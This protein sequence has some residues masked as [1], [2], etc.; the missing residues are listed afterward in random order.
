MISISSAVSFSEYPDLMDSS[1]EEDDALS[2]TSQE[3]L[4]PTSPYVSPR[5]HPHM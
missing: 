5:P 2:L 4:K 1:D 3:S